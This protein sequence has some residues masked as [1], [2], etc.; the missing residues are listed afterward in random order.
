MSTILP[1]IAWPLREF[2]MQ[3]WNVLHVARWKCMT[4][5]SPKIRHLGT[6]AQ[7]CRA[8]SSQLRHVSTIWKNLLNSNIS[9][10]CPYNMVNFGL[11]A[12]EIVSLVW[13]TQVNFNRFLHLGSVT[14]LHSSSGR[15]RNFVA[16][17]RGHH[18]YLAGWP[19]RWALTHIVVLVCFSKM[20]A[21]SANSY[22]CAVFCLKILWHC[23]IRLLAVNTVEIWTC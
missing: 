11:L 9:P 20:F 7:L 5:K 19:S 3:V 16:L 22:V 8:I 18:L 17:D 23:S 10:T 14:A 21:F 12:A 13:G 4:Q 1:H 15:Q 2:R 6:T